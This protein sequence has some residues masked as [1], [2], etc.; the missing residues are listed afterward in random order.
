MFDIITLIFNICLF[1]KAPQD[2]PYSVLLLKLLILIDLL[3]SFL[4]F[5]IEVGFFKAFLQALVGVFLV[6]ASAWL[7]VTIAKKPQ[8][9]CQAASALVGAD[10]LIS[11]FALPGMATMMT[12][13][14]SDLAFWVM[15]ALMIWHWLVTGHI[16]RHVLEQT[17]AFGLGLGFLYILTTYQVM[18]LLF[19]ELS[20]AN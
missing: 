13:Y 20:G 11:F 9:F 4:M 14:S 16:I 2:L 7:T 5:S 15:T 18:A 3:I 6:L 19:P 10:A 8:R 1:K 12:G 17:L